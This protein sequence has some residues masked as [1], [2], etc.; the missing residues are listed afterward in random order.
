MNLMKLLTVGRSLKPS[1]AML[2][3]YK[4][5]QPGLLPKFAS[6]FAEPTLPDKLERAA[7]SRPISAQSASLPPKETETAISASPGLLP[8]SKSPFE[9]TQKIV[10]GQILKRARPTAEAGSDSLANRIANK[11]RA[12]A[13]KFSPPRSRKKNGAR[14]VQTEW[15]LEKVTVARNDLTEADLEVVKPRK[16]ELVR[17]TA[18]DVL[19]AKNSGHEWI[20]KT[21]SLFHT[22]SPFAKSAGAESLPGSKKSGEPKSE[23]TSRM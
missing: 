1:G 2:G 13:R 6:P 10:V 9:K 22:P 21:R 20:K 11:A 12:I 17:P 3:K 7:T 23:L 15:P 14:A 19:A 4:L 18:A 5:T 16:R 8:R